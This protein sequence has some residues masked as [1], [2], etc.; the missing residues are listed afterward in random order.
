MSEK[1]KIYFCGFT[2][3]T[4]VFPIKIR[5]RPTVLHRDRMNFQPRARSFRHIGY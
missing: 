4:T 1:F 5:D 3:L 2:T